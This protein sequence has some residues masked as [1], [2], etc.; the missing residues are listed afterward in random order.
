[1]AGNRKLKRQ[2]QIERGRA[3]CISLCHQRYHAQ[4]LMVGA[5]QNVLTVVQL[6]ILMIDP[7][8]PPAELSGGLVQRDGDMVSGQFDSGRKS[9]I[10]AANDGYMLGQVN[11]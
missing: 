6:Q 10:T 1:M 8:R 11:L 9:C 4:G 5:D 7:A 2:T 3:A